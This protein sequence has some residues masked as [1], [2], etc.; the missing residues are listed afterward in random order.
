MIYR[1]CRKCM[2]NYTRKLC[3]RKDD[4]AM[5]KKI[6]GLSDYAHGH[7]SRN[8]SW[9]SVSFV[10]IDPVNMRTKFEVRSFFPS[11]DNRGAKKTGSP[12][13]SV[14][15][16]TL[17]SPKL[18]NGFLFGWILFMHLLNLKSDR[19]AL[20]VS[21]LIWASQKTWGSSW[22]CPHSIAYSL[23][24]HTRAIGFPSIFDWS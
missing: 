15:T 20:P 22:L 5:P 7:F 2:T 10:P 17:S 23:P 18:V 8:F 21:E 24:Y 1:I 4:R 19:L 9:P 16:P 6:S 12:C 14:D 11:S 3:Y 13:H